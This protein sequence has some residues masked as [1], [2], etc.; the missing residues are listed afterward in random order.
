MQILAHLRYTARDELK[1]RPAKRL[2]SP[3]A[4]FF[5]CVMVLA[6]LV[7][8][9]P[10]QALIDSLV[11]QDYISDV[12]YHYSVLL[13]AKHSSNAINYHQIE[14]EPISAL[15]AL[16]KLAFDQDRKMIWIYF[17][18][19]KTILFETRDVR[20]KQ[21]ATQ[22]MIK[23]LTVL[24]NRPGNF[25]QEMLLARDSLAINQPSMALD[26]YERALVLNPN[27]DVHFYVK[28]AQTAL[29][30]KQCVK[31]ADYYFIAQDKS[32]LID[33]KRY[34]YILALRLLFECNEYQYALVSAE[35][36]IDGLR[37]DTLTYQLLTNLA[38]RA[39][40]PA[41]AQEY[42]LKL[43]Q[44]FSESQSPPK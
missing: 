14:E 18:I 23:Y 7:N 33:D 10:G 39:N 26:F 43:L 34:F 37:H 12:D 30:A 28:V 17:L 2:L 25:N 24:K 29:W 21:E 5:F 9:Y 38:I 8:L 27:Q 4:I 19:V 6:L 32:I 13:G 16:N 41:K 3:W 42:V 22:T 20:V 44:L 1:P 36:H 31:S 35:K 40:E 11:N 15:H